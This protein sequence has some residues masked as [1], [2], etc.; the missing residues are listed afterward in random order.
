VAR[1]S[2]CPVRRPLWM[3]TWHLWQIL[4][5]SSMIPRILSAS[6]IS[7]TL[8]SRDQATC[9]ASPCGRLSRPRTTIGAPSPWGSHPLGD[10]EFLLRRTSE[11]GT[12]VP[13]VPLSDLFGHRSPT[14]RFGGSM[15]IPPKSATPSRACCRGV[16][17]F[18]RC[19][20][21]FKQCRLHHATRVSPG[22]LVHAFGGPWLC[23]QALVPSG[24][25]RQVSRSTRRSFFRTSPA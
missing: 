16:C 12:G 18:D 9:P 8:I 17:P 5:R 14:G 7:R 6:R 2:V 1:V 22:G 23:R 11:R 25:R 13:F 3:P 4:P 24:F 20:L 15:R 21:G 19:G 10:P